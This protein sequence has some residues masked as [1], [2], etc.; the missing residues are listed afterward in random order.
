MKNKILGEWVQKHHV[1]PT[2]WNPLNLKPV[3]AEGAFI[4]DTTGKKYIDLICGISVTILGHRHP[5]I[6]K[7]I[8]EQLN[9]YLHVMVWGDFQIEEQMRYASRLTQL[10]PDVLDTVIFVNSGSEATD[11]AIKLA[12][13]KTGRQQIV[14]FHNCYHGSTIGAW[15]LLNN[16]SYRTPFGPLLENVISIPFNDVDSLR[17]SITDSTA[18]VIME[19]IQGEAGVVPASQKFIEEVRK[20]CNEYGVLLIFDEVQTGFFRCGHSLFAFE[21]FN[22]V[23]DILLLGKAIGGGLPLSAVVTNHSI[24]EVLLDSPPFSHISTFGGHPLSCRAGLAQLEYLLKIEGE[25]SEQAKVWERHFARL[26]QSYEGVEAR[27][28]GLMG[29]IELPDEDTRNRFIKR[30]LEKG[31]LVDAFLWNERAI[32]IYPPAI[33][34][35]DEIDYTVDLLENVIKEVI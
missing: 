10:L 24:A 20:L 23:P 18:A 27:M 19:V 31:V 25:I 14:V 32:R 5:V 21:Q 28:V 26:N 6:V 9:R 33:L 29:A 22:V 12:R 15:S 1:L 16:I 17:K 8:E 2:S 3:K 30:A 13:K 34:S 35:Q 7:A 11:L 4:W